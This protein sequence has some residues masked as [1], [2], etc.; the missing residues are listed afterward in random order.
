MKNK[1][2]VEVVLIVAFFVF[3]CLLATAFVQSIRQENTCWRN[4]Y[5][6]PVSYQGEWYCFGREGRPDLVVLD[7]LQ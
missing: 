5:E 4:G 3:M 2:I 7:T 6:R 1:W